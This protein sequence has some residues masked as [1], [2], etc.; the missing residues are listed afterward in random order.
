LR[1]ADYGLQNVHTED[2]LHTGWIRGEAS[3]RVR[4]ARDSQETDFPCLSLPY[5]PAGEVEAQVVFVG[6]G[7]PREF[8]AAGVPGDRQRFSVAH[9]LGHLIF[10]QLSKDNASNNEVQSEQGPDIEA[11]ANRFASAFIVPRAAGLQE[12]GSKRKSLSIPELYILKHKYGFSIQ[13]WLHREAV[14]SGGV[15]GDCIAG[16]SGGGGLGA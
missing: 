15:V 11:L 10:N 16:S 2:Y 3:L 1:S 4:S 12:L 8:D 13:A 5:S 9:E 14:Q 7:G 6:T